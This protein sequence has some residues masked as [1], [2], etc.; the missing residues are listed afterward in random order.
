MP[1]AVYGHLI[2]TLI[3]KRPPLKNDARGPRESQKNH[4]PGLR[5]R[6]TQPRGLGR[7]KKSVVFDIY[8]HYSCKNATAAR[9]NKSGEDFNKSRRSFNKSGTCYDA[10]HAPLSF[11]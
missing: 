5:V 11:G 4:R 10:T 3:V 1:L 7:V 6:P 9:R 2:A 8:C